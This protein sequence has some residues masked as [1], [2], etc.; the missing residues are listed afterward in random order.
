MDGAISLAADGC[1]SFSAKAPDGAL[2]FDRWMSFHFGGR[3]RVGI[4][5]LVSIICHGIVGIG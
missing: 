5:V 4:F 1:L 2:D 3:M